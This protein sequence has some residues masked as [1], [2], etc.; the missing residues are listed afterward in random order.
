MTQPFPLKLQ[1]NLVGP[2]FQC[3]GNLYEDF[4]GGGA[5][6]AF[7]A[8]DVIGMNVG[9]FSKGFLAEPCLVPIF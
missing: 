5:L 2:H 4:N 9:L 8:T 6:A 7:N 3:F 1:K